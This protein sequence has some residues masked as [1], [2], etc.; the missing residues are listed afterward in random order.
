MMTGVRRI[1]IG[2]NLKVNTPLTGL[3]IPLKVIFNFRRQNQQMR[4]R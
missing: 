2:Q 1:H 4:T 3:S